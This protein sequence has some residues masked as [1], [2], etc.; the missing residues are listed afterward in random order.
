[1]GQRKKWFWPEVDWN[2]AFRGGM[3][4]DPAHLSLLNSTE[5][6]EILRLRGLRAHRGLSRRALAELVLESNGGATVQNPPQDPV[7]LLRKRLRWYTTT[8][9]EQIRDQLTATCSMECW[10]AP[11]SEILYCYE[12]N[13]ERIEERM[14]MAQA[15]KPEE[16]EE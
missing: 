10:N 8:F 6:V 3:L 5:L 14:K 7:D 12:A 13:R 4:V 1:M 9:K 15:R 11:P 16:E 2:E